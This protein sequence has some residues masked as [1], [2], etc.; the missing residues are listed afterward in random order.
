M[1][2]ERSHLKRHTFGRDQPIYIKQP[3]VLAMHINAYKTSWAFTHK[4]ALFLEQRKPWVR[5]CGDYTSKLIK[6][7][8]SFKCE[9][10]DQGK[11]KKQR[12]TKK[13]RGKEANNVKHKGS[14]FIGKRFFLV[15]CK[16]LSG[17]N[18]H[19]SFRNLIK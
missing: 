4:V 5:G 15:L 17:I 10:C 3:K 2:L 13:P 1:Y 18:R 6:N 12:K 9:H 16:K 11:A 19:F 14:R 7:V 8:F